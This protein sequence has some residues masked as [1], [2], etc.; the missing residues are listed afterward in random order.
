[1]DCVW[2]SRPCLFGHAGLAMLPLKCNRISGQP[3]ACRLPLAMSVRS[4]SWRAQM[5]I[6]MTGVALVSGMAFSL[7]IALLVE[8][9]IFGKVLVLFF[10]PQ[11]MRAKSKQEQ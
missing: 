3:M 1:V 6:I 2:K 5:Q 11:P 10:Q 7:A 4:A 8:E 9:L